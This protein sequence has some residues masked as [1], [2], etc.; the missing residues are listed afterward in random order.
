MVWKM[1]SPWMKKGRKRS[2]YLIHQKSIRS[3]LQHFSEVDMFCRSPTV[4]VHDGILACSLQ[5]SIARCGV[6]NDNTPASNWSIMDL[7][8]KLVQS[9]FPEIVEIMLS[10]FKS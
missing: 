4:G 3:F 10:D 1:S 9:P 5:Q 7:I 8:G 2:Y 6:K